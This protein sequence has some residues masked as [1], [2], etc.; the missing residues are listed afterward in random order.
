MQAVSFALLASCHDGHY[1]RELPVA[2]CGAQCVYG[3]DDAGCRSGPGQ[4]Q[5]GAPPLDGS[6]TAARD[7]RAEPPAAGRGG[8]EGAR[9]SGRSGAAGAAGAGNAAGDGSSGDGSSGDGSVVETDAR[10]D[11]AEPPAREC[12]VRGEGT[13]AQPC[14]VRDCA[15]LQA[16]GEHPTGV[17]ALEQDIDCAG[18]GAADD[19]HFVPLGS[20]AA[21][22]SAELDGRGKLI[23]DLRVARPAQSYVGLIGVGSSAFIH[24][25]GLE[26]VQILGGSY[27]GSF[28]GLLQARSRLERVYAA[29]TVAGEHLL[30]GLAGGL[31]ASRIDDS[32]SLVHIVEDTASADGGPSALIAGEMFPEAVVHHAYAQ[33]SIDYDLLRVSVPRRFG[34]PSGEEACVFD[35]AH[36]AQ[37]WAANCSLQYRPVMGADLGVLGRFVYAGWDFTTPVWGERSDRARPCLIW[38]RDCQPYAAGALHIEGTGSDASP[39]RIT[40]CSELQAM[41]RDLHAVYE[42]Q[43]DIDCS[44]FDYGDGGGFFPVGGGLEPFQGELRGGGHTIRGLR[45]VRPHLAE[46]GLFG[47]AMNARVRELNVTGAVVLGRNNV[48]VLAGYALDSSAEYVLVE[49]LVATRN[50]DGLQLLGTNGAAIVTLPE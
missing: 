45:I 9:D 21:P 28:A 41:Q 42:L 24:D 14:F 4:A 37:Y 32:Y 12:L 30:A 36:D 43:N 17:Y 19:T 47:M 34:M 25:L 22:F 23:V 8:T 27:V 3:C 49:G 11:A 44:G 35:C 29:G 46:V 33:G 13:R 39:Y 2:S 5:D 38:E 18:F 6:G 7:G 15:E 1:G 10:V 40:S 16:I 48:E 20:H 50:N 31:F 26:R